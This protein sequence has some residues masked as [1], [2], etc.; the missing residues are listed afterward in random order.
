[1]KNTTDELVKVWDPL[2]RLFHWTLVLSFV[3][4]YL[5][6]D[7]ESDLHIVSGYVVAGL[8][9]FRVLW[10]FIGTRHAR[11]S[12]FI[13]SPA[14]VSAYAKQLLGGKPPHYLGHNPFGGW[15]ILTLL[16]AL[17]AT[18]ITGLAAYGAENKG[19]IAGWV[20]VSTHPS[21]PDKI[22]GND[23]L[24]RVNNEENEGGEDRGK[25]NE[26]DSVWEELHEF[27]SNLTVVLIVVHIGGVFLG[28]LLHRENLVRAMVTG[29]KKAPL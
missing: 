9:V 21:K 1:M 28:S 20:A 5:S 18:S 14:T 12:D 11:F 4:A 6:G 24:Q 22:L 7:E 16:L 19:P 13:F 17:T 25:K 29:K 3:I 2:V 15:M 27:C 23:Y 26:E 8:V 10:G